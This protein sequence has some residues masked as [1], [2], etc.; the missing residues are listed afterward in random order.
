MKKINQIVVILLFIFLVGCNEKTD[1]ETSKIS[2]IVS[3]STAIQGGKYDSL[4]NKPINEELLSKC[5]KKDWG[6]ECPEGTM[7]ESEKKEHRRNNQPLQTRGMYSKAVKA[8][9]PNDTLCI[10]VKFKE[11]S[12]GLLP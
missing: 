2:P 5:I 10:R 9:P 11:F 4:E 7:S 1:R 3:D 12:T 8:C 6:Y